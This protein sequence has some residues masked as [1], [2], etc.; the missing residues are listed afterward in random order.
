VILSISPILYRDFI[1]KGLFKEEKNISMTNGLEDDVEAI[2]YNA[3]KLDGNF[4]L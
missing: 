4:D 2:E 3:L 1:L